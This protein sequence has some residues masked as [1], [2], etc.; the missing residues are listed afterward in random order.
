MEQVVWGGA[1]EQ[2]HNRTA[3]ALGSWRMNDFETTL[4][5]DVEEIVS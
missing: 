5:L 3:E 2:P 4:P 1:E